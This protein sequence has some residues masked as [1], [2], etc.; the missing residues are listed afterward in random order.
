MLVAK[1]DEGELL[2]DCITCFD[3]AAS[4]GDD[5][6]REERNVKITDRK[7]TDR[8][9]RNVKLK[10]TDREERNVKMT[11][12]KETDREERHVKL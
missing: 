7:E 8:E 5:K 1:V 11:Y 12:R 10:N 6:H 9:E 4:C 2:I 3:C